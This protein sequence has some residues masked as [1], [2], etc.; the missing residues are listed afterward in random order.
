MLD[1]LEKILNYGTLVYRGKN[2]DSLVEEMKISLPDLRRA[3]NIH[4]SEVE[5]L[6]TESEFKDAYKVLKGKKKDR[7]I[8]RMEQFCIEKLA[9]T[10]KN[11]EN[12]PR[13]K[14]IYEMAFEENSSKKEAYIWIDNICESFLKTATVVDLADIQF[15]DNFVIDGS[16]AQNLIGKVWQK[17]S[18]ERV[19]KETVEREEEELK[20]IEETEDVFELSKLGYDKNGLN[21]LVKKGYLIKLWRRC[22][23]DVEEFAKLGDYQMVGDIYQ[24]CPGG[25]QFFLVP[26]DNTKETIWCIWR[27]ICLNA[28]DQQSVIEFLQIRDYDDGES[29]EL[30]L[31]PGTFGI[32][33][34]IFSKKIEESKS[35]EEVEE[36]M[37]KAP[38]NICGG[39]HVESKS[40]KMA[41]KKKKEILLGRLAVASK[42]ETKKIYN[43]PFADEEVKRLAIKRLFKLL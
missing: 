12:V 10:P 28:K 41:K 21:R 34:E 30:S 29:D 24:L 37:K 3:L 26:G 39:F 42:V 9:L 20:K 17:L 2:L 31:R 23:E 35:L 8:E 15:I 25:D 36:W 16:R 18:S 4:L 40:E 27:D 1:D 5:F 11:V 7:L 33:D 22:L 32:L 43:S 14:Q 6:T 38:I 19:R 13:I